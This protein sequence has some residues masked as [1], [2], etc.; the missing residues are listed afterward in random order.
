M[1]N[2]VLCSKVTIN[3]FAHV[4]CKLKQCLWFWNILHQLFVFHAPVDQAALTLGSSLNKYLEALVLLQEI[5]LKVID[6]FVSSIASIF[7]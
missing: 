7:S 5:P 4:N 6:L 2:K 1:E 3:V